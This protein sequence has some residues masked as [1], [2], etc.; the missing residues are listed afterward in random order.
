MLATSW[1]GLNELAQAEACAWERFEQAPRGAPLGCQLLS[2][3]PGCR[4]TGRPS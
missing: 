4:R 3:C 1:S 2:A